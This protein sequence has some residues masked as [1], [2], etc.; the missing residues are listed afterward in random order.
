MRAFRAAAASLALRRGRPVLLLRDELRPAARRRSGGDPAP[1]ADAIDA[2]LPGGR[3]WAV[4]KPR[5]LGLPPLVHSLL[6]QRG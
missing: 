1:L 4:S 2:L 5:S 6:S 3:I